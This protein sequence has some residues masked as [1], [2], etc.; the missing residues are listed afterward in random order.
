MPIRHFKKLRCDPTEKLPFRQSKIVC[1]IGP[2][3]QSVDALKKLLEK[4]MNIVRMNFSHGSHEYHEVTV[5]NARL[6]AKELDRNIA[7]ALDTKGPEIRT[8]SFPEGEIKLALGQELFITT[9]EEWKN[10][11]SEKGFYVDYKPLLSTMAVGDRIYIDDGLLGLDVISIEDTCIRVKV[12]IPSTISSNKGCNLPNKNILLPAVSEKDRDDLKW[13][14]NQNL[15]MVFASFIR[16]AS[17]VAEVRSIVGSEIFIVSKIENQQGIDNIDEIIDISD[18][19]MIARGDL[20]VE[21]PPEMVLI[22]QKMIIAKC[23]AAGKPVICATQMLDSMTKN[24]RPTRAEVSDVGNAVIDG[25]DCIML[26]GE[27][28]KGLFPDLTV[29]VMSRIA[30]KAQL[31]INHEERFTQLASS[32]SNETAMTKIARSVSYAALSSNSKAIILSSNDANAIQQISRHHPPCPIIV[33]SSVAANCRR[34]SIMRSV[35]SIFTEAP[36]MAAE[37]MLQYAI[38]RFRSTD[39]ILEGDRV[40]VIEDFSRAVKSQPKIAFME[41]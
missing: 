23:N 38:S 6:A 8:G 13:A 27:T 28:A 25:A 16:S 2:S 5:S 7:I 41:V 29:Q 34:L 40:V 17:Q 20:G 15:D 1:T 9:D 10:K 31:C 22:A 35:H 4:G 21:V 18:G 33:L 32:S 3:T 36:N 30:S 19:I 39:S 37:E 14:K 26:S 11:G 24:P 12:S